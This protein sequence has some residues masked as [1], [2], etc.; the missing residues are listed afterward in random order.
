MVHP[1]SPNLEKDKKEWVEETS[2]GKWFLTT[3]IWYKYVLKETIL[4]LRDLIDGQFKTQGKLLEVGCGEGRSFSL[5]ESVFQPAS[6]V[7]VDIDMSLLERAEQTAQAC[8]VPVEVFQAS[9]K[10]MDF[11]ENTFD[12][13]FCH[14]LLH[15]I[16]FQEEALTEFKRV[17]KPGGKLL[18][19]ESCRDFL[20]VWWVK[21]FFRHPKMR[22][23]NAQEYKALVKKMGFE[24]QES[25]VL[26][27]TPWWSKRDL[28]VLEKYHL[29]FWKSSVSEISIVATKP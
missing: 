21:Y 7:A 28:G 27:T 22:Q 5:L 23:K 18:V 13:I 17:L 2:F 20:N 11:P 6:I 25:D 16:A 15:H 14:Q 3:D 1:L 9:A 10:S 19:S 29:Q 8:S 26:E 24:F 12:I 4:N